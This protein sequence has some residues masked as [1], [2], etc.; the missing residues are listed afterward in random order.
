MVTSKEERYSDWE[1]YRG[2]GVCVPHQ[3]YLLTW[4]VWWSMDV[5]IVINPSYCDKTIHV[6]NDF[7][8]III[9]TYAR[10][11]EKKIK[12]FIW[13]KAPWTLGFLLYNMVIIR[14]TTQGFQEMWMRRITWHMANNQ[15]YKSNFHIGE[16]FFIFVKIK[17]EK[18]DWSTG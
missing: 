12:S 5:Y 8:C 17:G 2:V 16:E 7:L 4:S 11:K 15:C 9:H 6:L 10:F 13:W 1:G 14:T 3:V 18:S